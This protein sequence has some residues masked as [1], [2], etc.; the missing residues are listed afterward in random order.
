MNNNEESM[1]IV[2]NKLSQFKKVFICEFQTI[3]FAL[4]FY[5]CP[6][7]IYNKHIISP[8]SLA[9]NGFAK[10]HLSQSEALQS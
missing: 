3:Q 8:Y 10:K 4:T 7:L 6:I 2:K 5:D 1:K 9:I